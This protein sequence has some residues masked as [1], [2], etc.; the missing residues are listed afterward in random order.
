VQ[1]QLDIDGGG[2]VTSEQSA[3]ACVG[4]FE[5]TTARALA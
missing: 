2:R 1:G 3:V 5:P 4:A